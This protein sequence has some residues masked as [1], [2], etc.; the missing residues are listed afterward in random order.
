MK[1]LALRKLVVYKDCSEKIRKILE[2]GEYT[3]TNSELDGFFLDGV[4]V[5]AVVGMNGC[6]KSSLMEILFRMVNNLS[7]V[8]LKRFDRSAAETLVFVEDVVADLYFTHNGVDGKLECRQESVRLECGADSFAWALSSTYDSHEHDGKR[9]KETNYEL[10]RSFAKHFFYTI[11]TNYSLQSYI[12]IDYRDEKG[13]RWA[14]I[15]K[16]NNE[17]AWRKDLT[18]CWL[19]GVFHK[20]DGYL[21]PIVLNPYRDEGTIDM[22]KEERLTRNRLIALLWETRND[23]TQII[24]GYRF[25]SLKY[26]FT[27][28]YLKSKFDK[29][30]LKS[31]TG[32][33]I[34]REFRTAYNVKG[35]CAKAVLRGYGLEIKQ[36][37]S[38]EE[39]T[40]LLYLV[41]KTLSVAKK[42]PQYSKF[43]SLGDVN[44]AFKSSI[45]QHDLNL[46]QTL[47]EKL[48][49]DDSHIALKIHQTLDL[50]NSL[51]NVEDKTSLDKWMTYQQ[52]IQKFDVNSECR[53]V[54]ERLRLLPPPLFTP[55]IGLIK[56]SKYQEI[57]KSTADEEKRKKLIVR[58]EV[59]LSKLSSGERQFIFMTSTL[60]YHSFNLLSI[61]E[62][63]RPAYRNICMVL[64]EV[65]I[66]FHPEYQRTFLNKLLRMLERTELNKK[67]GIHIIVVTHSP[68]VLSDIP[69][70]NIL[71]L[72]EGCNVTA[73]IE[74]DTFG[75][76]ILEL[77]HHN[78]FMKNGFT[79][80]FARVKIN[81]LI[82]QLKGTKVEDTLSNED[83]ETLIERVADRLMKQQLYY[84]YDNYLHRKNT[85]SKAERIAKLKAELDIL[86]NGVEYE[87]HSDN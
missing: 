39:V 2:P 56:E 42:Y 21:C 10:A 71:F 9:V 64:E 11:G 29:E 32:S 72:K 43:K 74:Q 28:A 25:A 1:K 80:E 22:M 45:N 20:N 41:Y 57:I 3:F 37:M 86:E 75:A 47:A 55:Q 66:C 60:I 12:S 36:D 65:E 16:K 73:E 26:K 62:D 4:T 54:E 61:P 50:I 35:S 5:S 48:K 6:G 87:T 23:D 79:G 81:K 59:S 63:E 58:N 8:L 67:F 30:L 76:N 84:L 53:S 44:L 15:N 68:F 85:S 34:D 83:I 14:L 52:Y 49:A 13:Y 69:K 7:A 24:E 17:Y 70:Q 77:L 51:S 78:F 19:N 33:T 27:N 40:L 38:W 82:D 31:F 46:L 18:N